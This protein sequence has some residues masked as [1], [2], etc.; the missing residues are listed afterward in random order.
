MRSSPG[1]AP[2]QQMQTLKKQALMAAG[3]QTL[4]R[5][6][7]SQSRTADSP[8]HIG[9]AGDRERAVCHVGQFFLALMTADVRPAA[10]SST[11]LPSL[12]PFPP[13]QG[14]AGG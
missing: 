5:P 12:R 10:H 2:F 14:R 13:A 7:K 4:E 11:G 9:A 8:Q 6:V 1:P 3:I